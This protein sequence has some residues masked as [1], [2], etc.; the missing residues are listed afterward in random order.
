MQMAKFGLLIL[1]IGFLFGCTSTPVAFNSAKRE[2]RWDA[3]AQIRDLEKGTSHNVSLDVA[4]QLSQAMRLEV[5]G[6]LG[7]H[8]ASVL[9]KGEQISYAVHPKKR[10]VYGEVSETS[11]ASLLK[12]NLDP[13]WF[14]NVFFDIPIS[15]KNWSCK[16]GEDQK[17]S[18]CNRL[19]DQSKIVW[20]ERNGENKRI[21][22]SNSRFE[23]QILVKGFKT[24]VEGADK[25][26][27]LTPPEGYTRYKLH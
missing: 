5:T 9:L 14:Y 13:R 7:V 6:T 12:V 10:F 25:I 22:I 18:E 16:M 24:K 19:S 17:V 11:L 3:K 27:Q 15:E 26:Y 4:S 20:T 1:S 2:G 8:I 21:T 23:V